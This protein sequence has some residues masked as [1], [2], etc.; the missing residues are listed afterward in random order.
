MPDQPGDTAWLERSAERSSLVGNEITQTHVFMSVEVV[1]P[2]RS[3]GSSS[4]FQR[5]SKLAGVRAVF[6]IKEMDT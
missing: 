3:K 2:L 6:V 1:V 4:K 5:G